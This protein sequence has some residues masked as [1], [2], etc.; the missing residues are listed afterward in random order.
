MLIGS[1]ESFKVGQKKRSDREGLFELQQRKKM[2]SERKT[3]KVES[4][5]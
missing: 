1:H 3:L 4:I 5:D 2:P